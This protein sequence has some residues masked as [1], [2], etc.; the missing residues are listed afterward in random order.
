MFCPT[1]GAESG[2][3]LRFCKQC[4]SGL[5]LPLNPEYVR[6]IRLTGAVWAIA[7]MAFL[8]F[9]ALCGSILGLA[10]MGVRDG[11][12]P[13]AYWRSRSHGDSR[14]LRA[15]DSDGLKSCRYRCSSR[16]AAGRQQASD[17]EPQQSGS[18]PGT[19]GIHSECNR[20]HHALV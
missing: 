3:G 20:E 2:E 6:P 13:R 1:C 16:N 7:V 9:G 17:P 11:G 19:S 18:D 4:G 5:T 14:H 12:Y 10:A 8:C 15:D